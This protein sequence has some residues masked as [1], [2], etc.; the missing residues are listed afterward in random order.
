MKLLEC[1]DITKSF[2]TGRSRFGA[3]RGV[4]FSLEKGECLGVV[5]ESGSG[6]S[7]LAEIAGGL[8]RPDSG[9]VLWNGRDISSLSRQDF[10]SYR[11]SVQY[12]F[13]DPAQSFQPRF[14]L[15]WSLLEPLKVHR[16]DLSK[17]EME[18]AVDSMALRLGLAPEL[19]EKRPGEVSGGQAQRAAIARALLLEPSLIIADECVSALDLPVQSQIMQLLGEV[20][21]D[22]SCAFLFISHD[23]ETVRSF[24]S[25]VLVTWKGEIVEEL[26]SS[27][28]EKAEHPYTRLLLGLDG[29]DT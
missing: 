27:G 29:E 19:L 7:T 23:M 26:A 12:V 15:R 25:R 20:R 1:R 11:K 13:Q 22:S 24:S 14:P 3:L 9:S 28:M 10:L 4:S 16:K 6:K 5:G 18:D 21:D 17:A 8:M 2:K